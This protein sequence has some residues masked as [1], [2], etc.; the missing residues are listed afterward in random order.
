MQNITNPKKQMNATVLTSTPNPL[1]QLT[2]QVLIEK[3]DEDT[4]TAQ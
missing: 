2:Y 1:T 3:H 4:S